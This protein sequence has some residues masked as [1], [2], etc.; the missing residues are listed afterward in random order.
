MTTYCVLGESWRCRKCQKE[1][2]RF[3]QVLGRNRG[4]GIGQVL[5]R[6]RVSGHVL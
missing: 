5:G 2:C 4:C 1:Y 6:D 3:R